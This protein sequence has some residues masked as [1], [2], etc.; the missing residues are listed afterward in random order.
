MQLG[1]SH[2]GLEQ[3]PRIE[4]PPRAVGD[5]AGAVGHHHMV[6]ELGIP[7]PR[8]P[9]GE[10]GGHDS[11]N[12][13]LDHAVGARTRVEHLALGVG[14]HDLD[15]AAM[16]GVDLCLGLPVGQR[17][18]GGHRLRGREGQVEPGH[19]RAEGPSLRPF[20]GLDA[21]PFLGPFG[22]GVGGRDG[23][24]PLGHPLCQGEV[25]AVGRWMLPLIIHKNSL[26]LAFEE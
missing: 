4:R 16:A 26:L 13:F 2:D 23:G 18:G 15:G 11:F 25:R 5:R 24:H 14:E 7:G 9:V 21:G 19:R 3:A 12:V 20:L 10:G 1:E 6:V 22:A 8:V 17:P